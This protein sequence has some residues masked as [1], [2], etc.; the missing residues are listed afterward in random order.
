MAE[1]EGTDMREWLLRFKRALGF[2]CLQDGV[3]EHWQ[4][5]AEM[6]D[7]SIERKVQEVLDG[8]SHTDLLGGLGE[9]GL[10]PFDSPSDDPPE[11]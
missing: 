4:R 8:D 5:E 3:L 10:Q 11:G 6:S 7:W 1:R 2:G 9:S